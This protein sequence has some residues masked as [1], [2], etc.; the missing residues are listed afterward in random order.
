MRYAKAARVEIVES[1]IRAIKM[2][3]ESYNNNDPWKIM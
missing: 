1:A 2:F 3:K